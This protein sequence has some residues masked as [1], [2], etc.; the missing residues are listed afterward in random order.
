MR[1]SPVLTFMFAGG[2]GATLGSIAPDGARF[3]S[4][5]VPRSDVPTT[6][7]SLPRHKQKEILSRAISLPTRADLDVFLLFFI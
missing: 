1:F 2:D 3:L 7:K 5:W 4:I 6:T